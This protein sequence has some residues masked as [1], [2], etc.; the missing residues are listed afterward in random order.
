M[1]ILILTNGEY[2]DYSFCKDISGYDKV[3]CADNG[4]KHARHLGIIP[5]YIIGD[6]DSSTQE[7]LVYFKEKNSTIYKVPQ[8]KDETDTE[9]AMDKAISLGASYVDIYGGVG[10][11]MDHTLGNIHL[12]Y[13]A[14][15]SDVRVSLVNSNN[16]IV[17]I[18][19]AVVLEGEV[20]QLVSL[21]P[22]TEE[23]TGVNTCGL[24]YKLADGIFEMGKPYGVSNYMTEKEAKVE[25]KTGKLLVIKSND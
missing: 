20:G 1:K 10:S 8:I 14:L 23:V 16:N 7:D 3:I 17:L 11:R 2:G 25:I 21:I 19:D 9:L 22:F 5:D 6:F 4:M 15:R 12:L 24:A 18:E 13:K